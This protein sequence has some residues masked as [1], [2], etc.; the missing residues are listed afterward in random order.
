MFKIRRDDT[1]LVIAGKDKGKQG[2]VLKVFPKLQRAIVERVN[3]VKKA[4]R[5]RSVEEPAGF[6]SVEAPIHISNLMLICKSCH[7]PTRVGFKILEDSTKVRY[8]KKCKA[9]F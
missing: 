2:R 6:V 3:L 5:R 4:V 9:T 1:V 8:C 7:Q